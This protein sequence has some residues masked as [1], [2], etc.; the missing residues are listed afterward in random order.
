MMEAVHVIPVSSGQVATENAVGMGS[1]GMMCVC[2]TLHGGVSNYLII[3]FIFT[4]LIR[5]ALF[6]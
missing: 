3:I 5:H 6:S 2:V 4:V 1:V